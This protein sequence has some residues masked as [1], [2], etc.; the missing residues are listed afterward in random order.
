MQSNHSYNPR[1]LRELKRDIAAIPPHGDF[2]A[3]RRLTSLLRAASR[4]AAGKPAP[5]SGVLWSRSLGAVDVTKN[6][7]DEV[8]VQVRAT[9]DRLVMAPRGRSWEL[10]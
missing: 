2:S 1:A 3:G 6:R 7:A 5:W 9:R 10:A 4:E 8:I